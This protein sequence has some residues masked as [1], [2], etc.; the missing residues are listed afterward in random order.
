MVYREKR[1]KEGYVESVTIGRRD[2]AHPFYYDLILVTK[3]GRYVNAWTS[4]K[5]KI[6]KVDPEVLDPIMDAIN[7]KVE[8]LVNLLEEHGPL[9]DYLE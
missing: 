7:G 4:I 3:E 8:T 1:G 6:S 2:M 5:R 9:E